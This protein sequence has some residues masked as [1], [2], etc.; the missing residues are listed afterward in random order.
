[1]TPIAPH[2]SAFLHN[3]LP[4][5]RGASPHTQETYTYGFRLLFD[6]ASQ[7]LRVQPSEI[8]L[9]QIDASLVMDFL[10][11]LERRR[12]NTPATRNVRLAAIK[13][14]FRF[15]EHRLPGALDQVRRIGAI[16]FK[17]THSRLVGYLNR[18]QMQAL[19]EAPELD[20]RDGI[21]DRALLHLAVATGLRVSELIALRMDDLELGPQPTILI[22]GKGR[23]ERMLPLWKQT[24]TTLRG[25][26]AVR[27]QLPVPEIFVNARA[28]PLSRWGVDYILNK[29]AKTAG[30]R[31]SS[32]TSKRLS[33]H[34][35]RH[36]CAM[37]ALQATHDIRKVALWLGHA[38][39]Q[40]TEIYTRADPTE[41]L[42]ALNTILPP[43]LR[44][45]RFRPEDKL[46]ALLKPP[47]LWGARSRP[48][49][50]LPHFLHSQLPITNRSP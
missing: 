13:S 21:R 16:P 38:S 2:I 40:T 43:A 33:P 14:F 3:Y 17:K 5:Q 10:E 35:L 24:A 6:F 48:N 45:S 19:T 49:P 27:G 28:Q 50:L 25:W 9:E 26:I 42:D 7:K 31:C 44:K 30:R 1:M 47:S 8:G 29:H 41:K 39:L 36:T 12:G 20:T 15:V 34:V 46:M 18:Q 22:R 11:H 37:L 4:S 23:R 32:L